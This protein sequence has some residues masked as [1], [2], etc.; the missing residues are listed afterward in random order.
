MMK[1]LKNIYISHLYLNKK[2]K[3]EP[4]VS[5]LNDMF[6]VQINSEVPSPEN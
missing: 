2:R 3:A 4:S 1:F 5:I 6:L